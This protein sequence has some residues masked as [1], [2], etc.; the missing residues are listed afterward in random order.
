MKTYPY[1]ATTILF[2]ASVILRSTAS[3]TEYDSAYIHTG[4]SLDNGNYPIYDAKAK[5]GPGWYCNDGGDI[6]PSDNANRYYQ[7]FT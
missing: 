6:F 3:A 5:W 4:C 2:F 7:Q 1:T